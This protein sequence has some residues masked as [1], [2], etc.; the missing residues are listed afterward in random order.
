MEGVEITFNDD[1]CTGCGLCAL[2]VCFVDAITV[3]GGNTKRDEEKCRICGRCAEICPKGAVKIKMHD[4]ALKRSL[5][6]VET[7][8]DVK[9]E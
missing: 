1:I 5:E 4:D 7:L 8:V 2:D 9:L 6:R 3:M